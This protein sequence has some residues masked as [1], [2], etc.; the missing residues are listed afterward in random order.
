M[1][2]DTFVNQLVT[3]GESPLWRFIPSRL[4]MAGDGT[5]QAINIGGETHTFTEVA[6]FGGGCV[7]EVNELLGLEAVPECAQAPEIFE[8]TIV[9]PW[10]TRLFEVSGD[11]TH[12]F[13]CV[14]HPWQRTTLRVLS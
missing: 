1:P 4:T 8:T 13:M 3:T 12:Y 6:A 10:Q 11:G 9:D 2:F 14:I 7:D 5:V